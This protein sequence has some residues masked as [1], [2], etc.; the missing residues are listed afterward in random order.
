MATKTDN[1]TKERLLAAA[2]QLFADKGFDAVSVRD[3]TARA[4]CN[5]AAVNYHFGGK[6][7][8]YR[9]IFERHMDVLRDVRIN[10]IK[11]VMAK[12][13]VSLEELLHAFTR[14]FIEPLL[15]ERG[16]RSLMKLMSREMLDPHLPHSL[17]I[18]KVIIPTLTV[19]S[20]AL[21]K[22]C[23]GL[24][25]TKAQLMIRSIVG[26]LLHTI[27]VQKMFGNEMDESTFVMDMDT[28]INHIVKFSAAGIR[29][30][31]KGDIE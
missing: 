13:E 29:A 3:L 9:K 31:E 10:A 30:Y 26:Q 7:Q 4:N 15:D 2:E 11:E 20:R 8:L 27:Q 12:N 22:I 6:E 19:F 14:S 21:I 1:L 5:V 24:D 25:E 23:P 17:F 16:G 28:I 18:E